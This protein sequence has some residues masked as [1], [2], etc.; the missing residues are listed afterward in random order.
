MLQGGLTP[1]QPPVP[2][3]SFL[4]TD[5]LRAGVSYGRLRVSSLATPVRGVRMPA[6]EARDL[7]AWCA[8]IARSLPAGA[9]FS[10]VTAAQLWQLPLP[11]D[12]PT[13]EGEGVPSLDRAC[14]R[15]GAVHVSTSGAQ[16]PIDARAVVPH[17]FTAAP[18][19][20]TRDGL[21]VTTPTQTFTD[22][23]ALDLRR[24][25]GE[26][27]WAVR[28]A[29]RLL[30]PLVEDLVVVAD[31][32]LASPWGYGLRELRAAVDSSRGRPGVRALRAAL[33]QARHRVDS[34]METRVR[35]RLV[36]S[37][38][39]CPVVGADVYDDLGFWV[40]RPDLSWPAARVAIEYD[41]VRHVSRSR[42]ARDVARREG[43]ERLGW[44]V[45]V[46]Y[47]EDVGVHWY[48]TVHRVQDA[49]RRAGVDPREIV[50]APDTVERPVLRAS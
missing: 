30:E 42:L 26:L 9:A 31:A 17:R 11:G 19:R 8:A 50:D 49:F 37:G 40:A 4:V 27:P 3:G 5:A 20:T 6:V 21:P 44:R 29:A 18:E 28:D 22:L 47:A 12:R 32:L 10:H 14:A 38:F 25:S 2:P 1:D 41:G 15:R 36:A 35:V 45:I 16:R 43:L 7:T 39:P 33:G 34:P 48:E 13:R 23:A 46:L 24:E